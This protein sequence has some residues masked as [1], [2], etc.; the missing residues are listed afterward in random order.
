MLT[1]VTQQTYI[2]S[3]SV[4]NSV[5]A[6][7]TTRTHTHTVSPALHSYKTGT[8]IHIDRYSVYIPPDI[9][10]DIATIR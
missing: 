3:Y 7:E 1:P 5:S 2:R 10:K 6:V 9:G 4:S 8:F